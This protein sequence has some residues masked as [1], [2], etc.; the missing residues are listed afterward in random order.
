MP[1]STSCM[2]RV[3]GSR[4]R[5]LPWEHHN[6]HSQFFLFQFDVFVRT[7][8]QMSTFFPQNSCILIISGAGFAGF[9]SRT[10]HVSTIRQPTPKLVSVLPYL[11]ESCGCSCYF[12]PLPSFI[13]GLCFRMQRRSSAVP[14]S[15]FW[16][17]R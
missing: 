12:S 2:N 4:K 9:S 11:T 13:R 15:D 16:E 5:I 10:T 7:S 8:H 3:P 6:V 14:S 17:R 1:P